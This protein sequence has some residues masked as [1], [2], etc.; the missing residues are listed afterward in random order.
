MEIIKNFG[1]NPYL[2]GAQIINFLILFYLLK[3]FAYKP[4]LKLLEDR[5]QTIEES[6]K[7]AEKTKQILD[8]TLKREKEIFKK[9][10]EKTDQMLKDTRNEASN[11]LEEARNNAK[12]DAEKLLIDARHRIDVEFKE[13][14]KKLAT[15]T[16]I[17]A[18][19]MLKNSLSDTFS[20]SLQKEAIEKFVKSTKL[21]N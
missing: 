20:D 12:K 6:L 19:N 9:A 16:Y 2:L 21:K 15:K 1:I 7:N 5:K 17:L 3:R 4:I 18:L 13:A 10:E 14:E 11:I 8:E